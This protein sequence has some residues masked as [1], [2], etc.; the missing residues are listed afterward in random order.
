MCSYMALAVEFDIDIDVLKVLLRLGFNPIYKYQGYYAVNYYFHILFPYLEKYEVENC[1]EFY[2]SE[3]EKLMYL[4]HRMPLAG[5]KDAMLIFL[6]NQMAGISSQAIFVARYFCH[7]VGQIVTS[8][9]SL[10]DTCAL[11]LWYKKYN[12]H[13]RVVDK[14]PIPTSLKRRIIP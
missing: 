8:P 2:K 13:E 9:R 6:D 4:C 3:V 10:R 12:R 7:L 5:L 1:A 11:Q 14:L